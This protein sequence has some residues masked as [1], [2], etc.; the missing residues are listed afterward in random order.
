MSTQIDLGPVL[1]IP[2]GDWNADTTYERL[3]IV[4]YNSASWICNVATSK[5]VEPTE[6]STD[7]YLQVKDTS[8][9]TSV[10]GMKGDV[11]IVLTETETPPA[12]DNSNRIATTEWVTDKL[13]DVDLS[14]IKDDTVLAAQLASNLEASKDTLSYAELIDYIARV[15]RNT[16]M[17]IGVPI[18]YTGKNVPAG[19]LR[20]DGATYTGM[21]SSFPEFYEWV[22]NSGLT[23]PLAD[24]V[25]VEGS[26]G[27][28]GLD[29][30]TGTVRMPTLAAGVFGTTVA[31][32]YGQAVQ[33]GLPNITGSMLARNVGSTNAGLLTTLKGAFH[34]GESG[35][36]SSNVSQANNTS[37]WSTVLLDASRSSAIYGKSD[38]VTPAHV[39]YPWVIVVYNAAVSPSVAQTGE[40]I[41]M[42]DG[43]AGVNA[44]NF[45]AEGK[46]LLAGLSFPAGEIVNL[47]LGAHGSTY[48]APADGWFCLYAKSTSSS[49]AAC[50]LYSTAVFSRSY[51]NAIN[52]EPAVYVPVIKGDTCIVYYGNINTSTA[53]FRFVY[54]RGA[55]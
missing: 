32:Q 18:P 22:V 30:A 36:A 33:A 13:G 41:E 26:C 53:T 42:L 52:T 16:G 9:V 55:E 31:G 54:A 7:W 23:V 1:S 3:N 39:K 37:G 46:S 48:T 15:E 25:L 24:Y 14:G 6:D 28:Y 27:Y 17:P 20:A 43:K 8:S 5:G 21:I 40:F 11:V 19:F 45:T 51:S 4:R 49:I 29:E 50:A 2:K 10:N 34:S 47:T 35:S 44:E 12:N 38:T